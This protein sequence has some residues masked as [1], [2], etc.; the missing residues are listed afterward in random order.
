M[1][2]AVSASSFRRI[3]IASLHWPAEYRVNAKKAENSEI[4]TFLSTQA[5]T[6]PVLPLSSRRGDICV[7]EI[8]ND[9]VLSQRFEVNGN[10]GDANAFAERLFGVP[11]TSRSWKTVQGLVRKFSVSPT[12]KGN[13]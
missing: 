10:A 6:V 2:L 11:G 9:V 12:A 8:Q 5:K 4:A 13:G 7:F 3:E 1:S